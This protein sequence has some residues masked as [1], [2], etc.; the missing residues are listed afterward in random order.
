MPVA[1]FVT[2]NAVVVRFAIVAAWKLYCD[3]NT[4]EMFTVCP[5]VKLLSA[6]KVTVVPLPEMFEMVAGCLY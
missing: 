2:V 1:G 6:V 3:G 5:A 4:P